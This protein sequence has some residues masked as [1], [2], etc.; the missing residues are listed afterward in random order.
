MFG[1]LIFSHELGHFLTAKAVGMRVEEF[2]VGMGPAIFKKRKGETLY[3]LRAF[4]AGGFVRLEGEDGEDVSENSFSNKPAWARFVVLV[5][6]A[7]MNILLGIIISISLTAADPTMPT[8]TIGSFV[9]GNVSSATLEVGD[10]I[11]AIGGKRV[12][13]ARDVDLILTYSGGEP[14]TVTVIRDGVKQDIENVS[15]YPEQEGGIKFYS[16]DF[17]FTRGEKN[18]FTVIRYG[19]LQTVAVTRS[20]WTSLAQLITGKLSVSN[21]SGPVGTTQAIGTAVSLGFANLM[22]FVMFISINLG[23]VNLLPFPA[24]D[25]GRILI[26]LIEKIIGRKIP[27]KIEAYINFIGFA[28]LMLLMV[29]VTFNDILKL[30]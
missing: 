23:I 7:V 3:S 6:G 12:F 16:R 25:G 4:P 5:A 1:I 30:F 14:I 26:L 10:E 13:I 9:D 22:Y 8:T 11:V 17:Y 27:E 28:L 19:F 2:S 20:I 24:L 21:L 15:F 18:F 29:F